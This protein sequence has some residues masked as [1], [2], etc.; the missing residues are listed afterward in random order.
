M[1]IHFPS[2][3]ER[4]TSGVALAPKQNVRAY[5]EFWSDTRHMYIRDL[6]LPAGLFCAYVS[7]QAHNEDPNPATR[8]CLFIYRILPATLRLRPTVRL[9]VQELSKFPSD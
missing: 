2:N 3:S 5:L 7:N 6:S 1:S 8:D 9:P 4:S